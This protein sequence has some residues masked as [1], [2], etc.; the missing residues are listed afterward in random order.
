MNA[1][2]RK[3]RVFSEDDIWCEGKWLHYQIIYNA[4]SFEY[5]DFVFTII[6]VASLP[7]LLKK[8]NG[9][10]Y[11]V[12]GILNQKSWRYNRAVY[13]HPTLPGDVEGDE[14]TWNHCIAVF[15]DKK[16]YFRCHNLRKITDKEPVKS[17]WLNN[18]CTVKC[19]KGERMGY[20]KR[21]YKVIEISATTRC[22]VDIEEGEI[23][24]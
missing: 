8:R 24:E 16:P 20:L 7:K 2:L 10:R 5:E 6:P 15:A 19:F 23:L 13:H 21:I 12:F 11:L 17:L 3:H 1:N 9:K 18:D 4:L 14:N 22:E